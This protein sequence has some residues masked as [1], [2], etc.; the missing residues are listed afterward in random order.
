MIPKR[1]QS[2]VYHAEVIVWLDQRTVTS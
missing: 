2:Y 1:A